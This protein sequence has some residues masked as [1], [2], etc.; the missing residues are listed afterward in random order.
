MSRTGVEQVHFPA[1]TRYEFRTCLT[2]SLKNT[3][4]SSCVEHALLT[5]QEKNIEIYMAFPGQF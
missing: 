1:I 5:K 4:T 2:N 3:M